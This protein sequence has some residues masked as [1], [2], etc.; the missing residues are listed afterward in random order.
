MLN[1]LA[2]AVVTLLVAANQ[3][4]PPGDAPPSADI[5]PT[6]APNMAIVGGHRVQPRASAGQ[7][8]PGASAINKR[9]ADDVDRLYEELMRQTAPDAAKGGGSTIP[10]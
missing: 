2:A 3:A 7:S 6:A 9:D 1:A 8:A 10:Q 5:P 4:P